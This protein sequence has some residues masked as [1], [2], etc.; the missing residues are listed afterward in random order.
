MTAYI[1]PTK[2]AFAEFRKDDREGP[3]H[4]LNLV[5]SAKL[6]SDYCICY[7]NGVA[8]RVSVRELK[9]YSEIGQE[10]SV[11]AMESKI[12]AAAGE[13]CLDAVAKAAASQ[14]TPENVGDITAGAYGVTP[15]WLTDQQQKGVA[16]GEFPF[17]ETT[18]PGWLKNKLQQG[19]GG[20]AQTSR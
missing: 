20:N 10:R 18:L 8:D 6:I 11:K 5:L 9:Q 7:A 13:P 14:V 15:G 12:A 2:Q 1:D 19:T 16:T 3:I 17:T 4:M